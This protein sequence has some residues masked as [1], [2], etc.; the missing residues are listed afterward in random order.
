M[1]TIYLSAESI[2][3]EIF[4]TNG[5]C[6]ILECFVELFI[7]GLWKI[8]FHFFL[9]QEIP[10]YSLNLLLALN[11]KLILSMNLVLNN[12]NYSPNNNQQT[13]YT[14]HNIHNCSPCD[15]ALN[16]V[17]N[18]DFNLIADGL[19]VVESH[20]KE[21]LVMILKSSITNIQSLFFNSSLHLISSCG[22]NHIRKV[23]SALGI[24]G[25][26]IGYSSTIFLKV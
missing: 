3:L 22:S 13:G 25:N 24:E 11:I 4:K 6:C 7:F 9:W 21:F 10:W 14:N 26:G 15:T 12:C 1:S 8:F 18:L 20:Q 16:W 17:L 19:W 2:G 5:A 23:I